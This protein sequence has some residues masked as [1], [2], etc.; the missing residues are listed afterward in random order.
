MSDFLID[1]LACAMLCSQLI[2]AAEISNDKSEKLQTAIKI[3]AVVVFSL[4]LVW[5]LNINR[6]K[7]PLDKV[8]EAWNQYTDYC[9]ENH[10]SWSEYTFP[11]WLSGED[12]AYD[13]DYD[14]YEYDFYPR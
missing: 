8:E 3:F 14:D 7:I 11:E 5:L 9:K 1:F 6:Q 4:V 10:I 12:S 13:Y 2:L